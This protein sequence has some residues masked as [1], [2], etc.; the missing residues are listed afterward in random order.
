MKKLFFACA[1]TIAFI[2]LSGQQL[3]NLWD[4]VQTIRKFDVQYRNPPHPILFVG[5]S[6]IR[7]WDG[8][9][10]AFGK[11]NVINR[12]IGGA[13]ISDIIFYLNDIVF[14]YQ[15]KQ[16]VLYVGEND[17]PNSNMTADS[18]LNQT[19]KLF[20]LIRVKLPTTPII[21]ISFKPSPSRD[22]FQKKAT[23]AVQLIRNFLTQE[24]NVIY[25]DVYSKM[26][27]DGKSRPELFVEDQLHMNTKGYKIW[28]KAIRS[29]LIQ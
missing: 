12:G 17:V 10:V 6:S 27:K 26:L 1:A 28:E 25:I 29:Y 11:Y 21:Y 19:K 9:Q 14:P 24:R 18:I 22:Q 8:L 7:K 16:I 2:N 23:E 4:E 15:P 20:R 13:V 5:S 3:P